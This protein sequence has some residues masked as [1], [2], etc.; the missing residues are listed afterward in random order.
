MPMNSI[1]SHRE[2]GKSKKTAFTSKASLFFLPALI[3]MVFCSTAFSQDANYWTY[4]YGSR[5]TLLGGAVVGSV[6]DISG[7]Y[8]NP[9]GLALID[10]PEVFLAARSFQYPNYTLK[11]QGLEDL[12]LNSSRIGTAPSLYAGMMNF[13]FLKKH[14]ITYAYLTRYESKLNLNTHIVDKYASDPNT[15]NENDIIFDYRLDEDLTEP[16][17]GI[18]WSY[19]VQEKLGIGVSTF[20]TF[21]DHRIHFS[22]L[23]EMISPDDDIFVILGTR[24]FKYSNYRLLWKLG[25][26]FDF[27]GLSFGLTVT[28]PSIEVY[29]NGSAGLNITYIGG[30]IDNN[31]LADTVIA[32]TYQNNLDSDYPTPLSIGI[33]TTYKVDHT[34]IYLSAEWFSKVNKFDVLKTRSFHVQTSGEVVPF[35]I[36]HEADA[37][38]NYG[39]GI[40]H[41]FSKNF[42]YYGSFNTDY[43]NQN[44]D[45]QS[46]ISITSWNIYHIMTGANLRI[47][48][49]QLTL[50][51]GYSF[52]KNEFN[53]A[54]ILN[55]I[56]LESLAPSIFENSQFYYSNFRLLFGFSF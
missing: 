8:Y 38:L 2:T 5:S 33:G 37:V 21:R 22:T 24:D 13:K 9:G 30:D 14:R 10:D 48:R 18:T 36:T 46:N 35:T 20:A 32:A 52:G 23:G 50:G 42:S 4:Q 27:I 15:G 1:L 44:S 19:K 26:T 55:E 6:L 28:T 43:S 53:S 49:V 29:S 47:K 54:N 40:E 7:I 51:L 34:R 31:G 56:N 3:V 41:F 16:W 11:R 25:L 17:F 45:L 39:I 12:K